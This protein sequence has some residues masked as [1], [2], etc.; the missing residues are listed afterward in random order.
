MTVPT[1]LYGS[2]L[3]EDTNRLPSP[4]IWHDM[5]CDQID[6]GKLDGVHFFEDF[7]SAGVAIAT[8][9]FPWV[10]SN[11]I[12]WE[13]FG[14]SGVTMQAHA[15]A[16]GERVGVLEIDVDADDE[17]AYLTI[18]DTYGGAWGAISDT[19]GD[20]Y[21]LAFE[22]RVR[23]DDVAS[24]AAA[25]AK[26]IGLSA[27]GNAATGQCGADGADWTPLVSFVGFRAL[28]ADG[29]GMDC[30]HVGSSTEV[31]VTE[32][33]S[34][35]A[36]QTIEA[37]TYVRLGIKFDGKRTYWFV[38]GVQIQRGTDGVLPAATSFPDAIALVPFLGI[39]QHGTGDFEMDIDWVRFCQWHY[40]GGGLIG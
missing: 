30:V 21:R 31:V 38:N 28:A 12:R 29:D 22:C 1:L 40:V 24:G 26:C 39:R 6:A 2:G 35:L 10:G 13:G 4:N 9:Q 14:T 19:S 11:G 23:W 8:N 34:G 7:H 25:L 16:A 5:K 37:D 27:T 20:N 32:S 18:D 33:A 36:G 15:E 3:T 17:E